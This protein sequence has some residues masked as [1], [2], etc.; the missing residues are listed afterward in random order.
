[1]ASQRPQAGF[2]MVELLVSTLLSSLVMVATYGIYRVQ[3]HSVRAQEYRL[4][5]QEYGRAALDMMVREIRNAG[6]NPLGALSGTALGLGCGVGF[7]AG[8]PGVVAADATTIGFTYDFQGGITPAT[9]DGSC[10][11]P[12][13]QIT[14]AYD[15]S[16][17]PALGNITRN[18]VPLTDCNVSGLDLRYFRPDG[19]ELTTR[20]V[21]PTDLPNI[22]RVLI[23]LS[24]RS[25][26]ADQEFGGP[27]VATM[28]SN[29]DLRNR[30][31][32][33]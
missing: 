13:E 32:S 28:T 23:T 6:L 29:A 14:Y 2:T 9:P 30:G 26:S 18:G 3:M 4:D 20:P 8:A 12:D 15:T 19:T 33:S 25:K 7:A 5:A 27:F 10:D 11:D 31:L 24:I 1:M 22:Q 16:G 21:A 17:C